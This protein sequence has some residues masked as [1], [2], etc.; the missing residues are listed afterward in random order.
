VTTTRIMCQAT[1]PHGIQRKRNESDRTL[2]LTKVVFENRLI[3]GTPTH[4]LKQCCPPWQTKAEN[5]THPVTWNSQHYPMETTTSWQQ[6]VVRCNNTPKAP[7]NFSILQLG[8]R[9]HNRRAVAPR[10]LVTTSCESC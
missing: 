1:P 3:A 5:N 9:L 10:L 2:A 8:A 6:T 4:P 7:L